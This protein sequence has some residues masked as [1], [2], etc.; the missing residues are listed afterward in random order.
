MTTTE[1]DIQYY[2]NT[3]QTLHVPNTTSL[4]R[5]LSDSKTLD[6]Q[7]SIRHHPHM[8]QQDVLHLEGHQVLSNMPSFQPQQDISPKQEVLQPSSPMQASWMKSPGLSG[9]NSGFTFEMPPTNASRN[10]Q[11]YITT[12]KAAYSQDNVSYI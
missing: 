11:P 10:L 9:M 3:S 7:Q 8:H 6:L 1:T 12:P 5:S 4:P 2:P